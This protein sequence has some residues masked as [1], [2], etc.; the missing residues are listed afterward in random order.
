MSKMTIYD[1]LNRVVAAAQALRI[2]STQGAAQARKLRAAALEV[3]RLAQE[4]ASAARTAEVRQCEHEPAE[5]GYE[6]TKVT[7]GVM[8]R[9]KL[10]RCAKCG[11]PDAVE[12]VVAQ[13]ELPART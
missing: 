6:T 13:E 10:Y 7:G 11:K 8:R 4:L 12:T 3:K 2:E 1:K 5:H 9:V